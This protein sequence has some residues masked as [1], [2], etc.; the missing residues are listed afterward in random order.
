MTKKLKAT[1]KKVAKKKV[2]KKKK[3]RHSQRICEHCGGVASLL[4][5]KKKGP[6]HDVYRC[7]LPEGCGKKTVVENPDV[8]K[9]KK[10]RL[11]KV[12][13]IVLKI[14]ADGDDLLM[15]CFDNNRVSIYGMGSFLEDLRKGEVE[16]TPA[17]KRLLG[18]CEYRSGMMGAEI[19]EAPKVVSW[20][21]ASLATRVPLEAA[22][23]NAA[24]KKWLLSLV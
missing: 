6:T 23:C 18:K 7:R 9:P 14:D 12:R 4:A 17:G 11:G 3:L 8:P 21:G 13:G 20:F 22:S 19:F 24:G 10:K 5:K 2:A 16:I 1:K 15:E